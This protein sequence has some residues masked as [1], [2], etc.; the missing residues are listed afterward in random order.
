MY[1]REFTGGVF[2]EAITGG[3]AGARVE[4]SQE[5]ITATTV[6]GERFVVSFGE[7]QV[8]VGGFNG[9]MLF[10]R[11]GDRSL[12]IFC[13]DRAFSQALSSAAMGLLDSQ[14]DEQLRLRRQEKRWGRRLGLA[15]LFGAVLLLVGGFFAIRM[16]ARAAVRALPIKVDQEIGRRA[17]QAMD[18]GGPELHDPQVVQAMQSIVDR[19]AP[20]AAI[21]GLE[22]EVHV[23]DSPTVNAFALP[24]GTIVV[25]T[26]LIEQAADVGQI[27]GVIGHEMA[28]A[29]LRHG[30]ERIGQ[31]VGMAAAVDLLL[32]DVQGIIMAG[33]ELFQLA[34]IN[35]YS[36]EQEAAAD[37]EAVVMM[38]AADLDPLALAA[39]FENLQEHDGDL[40]GVVS[41]IS[42][43]PQHG[44]RIAAVRK[45]TAALPAKEYRPLEIDL[46]SLQKQIRDR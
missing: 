16:G 8:E 32:G 27:A 5:G 33:A 40:P 13:E 24:G 9:R 11:N 1:E 30:L 6:E 17:F 39:F 12:T 42:T 37:A 4:L 35:S 21:P 46:A 31:A 14:I 26:G 20:H 44:E 23:I 7:C 45:Q 19:M 36:R 29:T 25:Y 28:H 34:S 2:S 22:F 43:H 10:C 38:H 3:R 15:L 41:W 18:L